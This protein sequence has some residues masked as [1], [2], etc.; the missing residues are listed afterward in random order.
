MTSQQD[1]KELSLCHISS[2]FFSIVASLPKPHITYASCRLCNEGRKMVNASMQLR[3][4]DRMA[5][6]LYEGRLWVPSQTAY[7]QYF[8]HA[9]DHFSS[10]SAIVTDKHQHTRQGSIAHHGGH[11]CKRHHLLVQY[12]VL[13]GFSQLTWKQTA[14]SFD[15]QT[16][17]SCNA[18]TCLTLATHPYFQ[19]S[20]PRASCPF[21]PWSDSG[22]AC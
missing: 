9:L 16:A 11:A 6:F 1:S 22:H 8:A 10:H 15:H 18:Y 4:C 21:S 7:L 19:S 13:Q 3:K 20:G 17:H 14:Y 2:K 12:G 5:Q